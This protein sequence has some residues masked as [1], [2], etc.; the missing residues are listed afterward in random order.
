MQVS[1]QVISLHIVTNTGSVMFKSNA[2]LHNIKGCFGIQ[3]LWSLIF[4][5]SFDLPFSVDVLKMKVPPESGPSPK[6]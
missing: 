1:K 4:P 3:A 2:S 5:W 6:I